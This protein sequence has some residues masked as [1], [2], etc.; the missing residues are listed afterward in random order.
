MRVLSRRIY[1]ES[2][3]YPLQPAASSLFP[4]APSHLYLLPQPGEDE[5]LE[6]CPH[7]SSVPHGTRVVPWAELG[8]QEQWRLKVNQPHSHKGKD[9]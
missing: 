7:G 6:F 5:Q 9:G 2:P 8:G 1:A 3:P 4:E